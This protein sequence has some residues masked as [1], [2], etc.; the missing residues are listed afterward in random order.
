MY[1][2]KKIVDKTLLFLISKIKKEN[3]LFKTNHSIY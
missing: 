1:T 3:N 2:E